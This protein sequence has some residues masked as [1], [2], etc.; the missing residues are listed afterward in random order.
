MPRLVG[1]TRLHRRQ[2]TD[3]SRSLPALG[4]DLFDPV[5]LAYVPLPQELD[6]DPMIGRQPLSVLAK[7]IPKRLG[8][9]RV[10]EDADLVLV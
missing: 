1:R 7:L 10:V 2:D 9:S 4:Q 5:F 6:L 8:E 3:Q